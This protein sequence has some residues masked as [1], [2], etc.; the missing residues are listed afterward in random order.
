MRRM[1]S[2]LVVCCLALAVSVA[3]APPKAFKAEVQGQGRCW[4]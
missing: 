4:P 1:L 2:V 3:A